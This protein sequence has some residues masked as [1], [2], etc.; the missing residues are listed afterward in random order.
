VLSGEF[1]EIEGF[2]YEMDA[3]LSL[4]EALALQAE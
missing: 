3:E 2:T 1:T 4:E